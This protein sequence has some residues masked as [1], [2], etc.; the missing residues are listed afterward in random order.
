MAYEALHA[1]SDLH[2]YLLFTL[3]SPLTLPRRR[4]RAFLKR[5]S[6]HSRTVAPFS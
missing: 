2:V 5:A 3:G 1:H 6:A 4:Q